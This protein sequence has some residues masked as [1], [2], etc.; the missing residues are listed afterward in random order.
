MHFLGG[1]WRGV[2]TSTGIGVCTA[3]VRPSPGS[4][5]QVLPV[6]D[7]TFWLLEFCSVIC[8]GHLVWTAPQA[9]HHRNY[10]TRTFLTL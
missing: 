10:T 8:I 2:G 4:K 3:E 7:S 5:A 1:N 6:A 9:F